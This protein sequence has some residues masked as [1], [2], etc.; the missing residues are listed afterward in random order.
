MLAQL[1]AANVRVEGKVTEDF[2][3]RLVRR[4]VGGPLNPEAST[5]GESL[6]GHARGSGIVK[7]SS[8][9]YRILSTAHVH[10]GDMPSLEI[11]DLAR[12]SACTLQ[13]E[14]ALGA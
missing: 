8:T 1:R 6:V 4:L 12:Q 2:N 5:E 13:P 14:C 7:L 3:G 10:L 9:R 11:N